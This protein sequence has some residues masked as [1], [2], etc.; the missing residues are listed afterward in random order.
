MHTNS[1]IELNPKAYQNNLSFL[2]K[3]YGKN[4]ILSSVVKGNA[5]GHGIEEFVTMANKSGVSHFSVFAESN[6]RNEKTGSCFKPSA[7]SPPK[8]PFALSFFLIV[9]LLGYWWIR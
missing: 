1:V 7:H 5:Y 2:K 6:G 9:L 8:L 4:V 3:M